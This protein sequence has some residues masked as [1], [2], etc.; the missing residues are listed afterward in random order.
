MRPTFVIVELGY[1]DVTDAAV[2]GDTRALPEAGA[3][4]ADYSKVLAALKSTYADVLVM[5]VPDPGDTAYFTSLEGATR[6]VG[7]P[8]DVLQSIYGLKAD[9]LLT[10][11]GLVAIGGQLIAQKIEPLPAGSVVSAATVGEI[12]ARVKQLNSEISSLAQ[13]NG[14]SVFDLYGHFKSVRSTGVVVGDKTLTS[15][16][17]GGYYAINGLYPSLTGQAVLANAV[18][19]ELNRVYGSSFQ[20][21]DVNEI[22]KAD[23][24]AVAAPEGMRMY[25]IQELQ[26]FIP[27]LQELLSRRPRTGPEITGSRN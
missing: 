20:G 25:S 5:T 21:V 16:Y 13:A 11:T 22:A 2:K 12:T 15:A 8:A 9:D 18:I 6:L 23:S 3:F 10:P 1:F 27:N 24:G 26:Q 4:R 17:L 14:A 7:A 19:A